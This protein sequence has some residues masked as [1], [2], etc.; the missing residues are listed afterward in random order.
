V[1]EIEDVLKLLVTPATQGEVWYVVQY[2]LIER[3]FTLPVSQERTNLTFYVL[4]QVQLLPHSCSFHIL[5][6]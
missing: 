4:N 6:D 2:R 1:V 3:S 5:W